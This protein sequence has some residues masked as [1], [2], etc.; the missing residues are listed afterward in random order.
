MIDATLMEEKT[1]PQ[2]VFCTESNLTRNQMLIWLGQALHPNAPMYNMAHSFTIDGAV[3]AVLFRR[4]FQQLVDASDAM[5]TIFEA[6]IGVP[7]QRVLDKLVNPLEWVDL[8]TDAAPNVA[9]RH[10]LERRV[11]RA[12]DVSQCTFDSALIKLADERFVWYFNQ[13]HLITD[14][15][16]IAL[17]FKQ[18]SANYAALQTEDNT[19]PTP[20]PPFNNYITHEWDMR[21]APQR[22]KAVEFWRTKLTPLPEPVNF[23]G[24]T[25]ADAGIRTE[26]IAVP[27]GRAR[28]QQ[29]RTLAQQ[30][31]IR[32]LTPDMTLSSIFGAL[33]FAYLHRMG[34]QERLAI[35]VPFHNRATPAFKQTIGLFINL[36]PLL[37]DIAPGETFQ[38][39]IQKVQREALENLRHAHTPPDDYAQN[40]VYHVVLNYLTATFGDFAGLPT[41][42]EWIHAGYGDGSHAL[43]LQVHDFSQK[44]EI[45]LYFDLNGE[46]FDE[47]ARSWV[48]THFLQ[49][50]DA[51]LQQ[52][53]RP[54]GAL[55][56]I[57]TA[58]RTRFV[59]EF[60]RTEESYPHE[61]TVVQLFEAQAARTPD[62]T[63]VVDGAIRWSY[64]DLNRRADRLAAH[65]ATLGVGRESLVGVCTERS[66]ETL[67][68][69]WGVLKAGAAYVPLDAA[70]PP[71]RLAFM[72]EE[73]EC[74]VL[75]TQGRLLAR[76]PAFGGA[77][78]ALDDGW[79]QIEAT[80]VTEK[81]CR[82]VTS[83]DDLAYLIFTSGSTGKPKGAMIHH[84][85][86]LNY[87]WWARRVYCHAQPLDFPLF[88]SLSFDLTVT[89][90]FTPLLTGGA[91]V[92][93]GED[94]GANDLAVVR[95]LQD[96]AVDVVKLTPAHLALVAEMGLTP[97]RLTRMIVGGED[98]KT[99]LARRTHELLQGRV[100]IFNEYGPT[101]TVVGC[102]IHQY[103]PAVD[104]LLSVP[105]GTPA[106]NARIYLLDRYLQPVPTG[107][108]GEM[109]VAGD[110]VCRGY[111]K[112]PELSAQRFLADP[113]SP[114]NSLYKT[115]D[116]ARWNRA[117]QLEF[118]GRAD[119][120]VKIRGHRIELGEIEA[121]LLSHPQV[122]ECVVALLQDDAPPAA[123]ANRA[124]PEFYCARCGLPA[125]FPNIT[126][127]AECICSLCRAYEQIEAQV[128][129]YFKPMQEL[130]A[131]AAHI[132]K[133]AT[134]QYDS[135]VLLSGGKDSTYMLYKVV[136]LGLRPLIFTLD[137]GYIS[138]GAKANIR[139]VA[140]DLG[141]D[142]HF[143]AT[144]HMNAIFVESLQKHCNVCNG[145]FKTIYTLSMKLARQLGIRYIFTGLARGQLF[146]TRLTQELFHTSTINVELI[147]QNILDARM[148]Y[149]RQDDLIAKTLD[150]SIFQDDR[151]F[152]EIQFVD[153]YRYCNV[154]LNDMLAYLA[155]HAPWIRPS[156]TGRSTNCLINDVGIY[157]HKEQRGYH[158]YA[159]PYSW[160]VRLGHKQRNAALH[161]LN[162]DIDHARVHQILDEIGYTAAKGDAKRLV[163]YYTAAGTLSTAE[164][165]THLAAQLPFYM[166]PAHIVQLSQMP[167]TPNGKIDRAALPQPD[168][169]VAEQT[170]SAPEG[171][172][173]ETI[174]AIW[175]EV[176]RRERISVHHNFFDLGG[177]SLSAIQIMARLNQEFEMTMPLRTLFDAPTVAQLSQ[178]VEEL[179]I[180]EIEALSEAEAESLVR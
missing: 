83:P 67:V 178:A 74:P 59:E 80:P 17:I 35:G 159:L 128:Q 11:I 116:L 20:L 161:E 33:L 42:F 86:L 22:Q 138:Q 107:V 40:R 53:D 114:G 149:H 28:S 31:G 82:S 45:T 160:D 117:G 76:L 146:E 157:V 13:H 36:F 125:N 3:D 47:S 151:I 44:G 108:V 5:R 15:L 2:S 39:L 148:A 135:M 88:S 158:N 144:P 61:Q 43:R 14:V 24:K 124:E 54:I 9:L 16:S 92:V 90:I 122:Q 91:V 84:Q 23:Y 18:L 78:I 153:F 85:G 38:S 89:S 64:V 100:A 32:T 98:F 94:E 48:T 176:L 179:L 112:R 141:L 68:A 95:V 102:M 111:L 163:A 169:Q 167:L 129:R 81:M 164:A 79:E 34:G 110:G 180:S 177:A 120:Q 121:S 170:F 127:D 150:V 175:E 131:L 123:Q 106:A 4:A 10:W 137:N 46:I 55:S 142:V 57:S 6:P 29:L 96:D 136:E 75:I 126:F 25:V 115:G 73:I 49:L 139:R 101:E 70:Y 134:G 63:A 72:I 173:E 113:F 140:D 8:S 65:L 56:L 171:P 119:Y 87:I 166:L 30:E 132:K 77:T 41:Q 19:N 143:G 104:T 52:P 26:R 152:D 165:R 103:D 156:D 21:N 7:Q 99:S 69:I 97:K 66:A 154:E 172:L 155:H 130:E 93:Y 168:A 118:L 60:N 174:A 1:T 109:Y 105:I 51:F 12:L 58:E 37:A 50:L 162:D 27:L 147:D 62:A 145:C 71:E 133:S